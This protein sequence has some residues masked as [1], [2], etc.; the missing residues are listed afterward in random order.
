MVPL[1]D[2]EEDYS[3]HDYDAFRTDGYLKHR[4]PV[5]KAPETTGTMVSFQFE[6]ILVQYI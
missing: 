6:E 2:E 5:K 3:D 4:Q 1:A